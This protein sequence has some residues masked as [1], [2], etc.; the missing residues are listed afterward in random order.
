MKLDTPEERFRKHC[1]PD[2]TFVSDNV[3]G[4]IIEIRYTIKGNPSIRLITMRPESG[5]VPSFMRAVELIAACALDDAYKGTGG[6]LRDLEEAQRMMGQRTT[7]IA[8][9]RQ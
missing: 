3:R 1:G 8:A 4:G 5:T 6:Y 7:D 9:G 2:V